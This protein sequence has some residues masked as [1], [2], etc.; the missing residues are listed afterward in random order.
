MSGVPKTKAFLLALIIIIGLIF[1]NFTSVSLRIKNFFY[2]ISSP[3]Q[4][5]L[6]NSFKKIKNGLGFFGS[7]KKV[8]Q[9]N[10]DLEEEVN[11]LLAENVKLREL[12]EE[13]EFLSSYLNIPLS[14]RHQV[15]LANIVGRDFQGLEKYVL[16]DKGKL[17]GVSE[18]M[19]V[20][21][22][23]NMLVGRIVEV[24]NDFSKVLLILSTNSKIPALIQE[25]R[26]EGLILGKHGGVLSMDLIPKDIKIEKGQAVITS[27]IDGIFPK[28]LLIGKIA[29]V[30]SSENEM[31]Q[32]I[33]VK[34]IIEA[35]KIE[36]VF[37]IIKSR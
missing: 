33:M 13:N 30:E 8:Y 26:A 1:L 22:F 25:S 4:K 37:I 32:K 7:F 11:N 23:E 12:K 18:N 24:F 36:R 16:I 10:I 14:Q 27:G 35:E 9:K 17:A 2:S 5:V 20:V 15:E 19:P 6:D 31:F 3:V 28:G 29:V 21:A 34:P